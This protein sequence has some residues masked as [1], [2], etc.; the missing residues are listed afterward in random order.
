MIFGVFLDLAT[1]TFIGSINQTGLRVDFWLFLSLFDPM[2]ACFWTR[3]LRI[4]RLIEHHTRSSAMTSSLS[5]TSMESILSLGRTGTR[6]KDFGHCTITRFSMEQPIQKTLTMT[7]TRR[8][9][10]LQELLD[11]LSTRTIS[12]ARLR[13]R[14]LP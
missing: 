2:A 7:P 12:M 11:A 10:S 3:P 5:F 1:E 14:G 8:C 6:T 4:V 13:D 9:T